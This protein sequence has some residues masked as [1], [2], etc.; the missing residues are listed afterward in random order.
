MLK[1]PLFLKNK[2]LLF[3]PLNIFKEKARKQARSVL[4]DFGFYILPYEKQILLIN[5]EYSLFN[6]VASGNLALQCVKG[7]DELPRSVT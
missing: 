1:I 4:Q 5:D 7:K 2:R 3:S 6:E